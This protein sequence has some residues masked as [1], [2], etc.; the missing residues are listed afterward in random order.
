M[1]FMYGYPL[2]EES[3]SIQA[4][5][6]LNHDN[7]SDHIR[8]EDIREYLADI[9]ASE[10][11]EKTMILIANVKRMQKIM[12]KELLPDL[13]VY[14]NYIGIR[15]G[16]VTVNPN[17]FFKCRNPFLKTLINDISDFFS[18]EYFGLP[19]NWI[20][21]EGISGSNLEQIINRKYKRYVTVQGDKLYVQLTPQENF[22][23]I[24]EF[25]DDVFRYS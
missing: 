3:N 18:R 4:F 15:H 10:Y 23:F 13:S 19:I 11:S 21:F 9:T 17:E 5:N 22:R 6:Y 25:I 20:Y 14:L 7:I 16:F 1:N 12:T 24:Y 2:F 8:I